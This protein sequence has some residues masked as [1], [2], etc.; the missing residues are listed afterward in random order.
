M[1]FPLFLSW[2]IL[3]KKG[4]VPFCSQL[5]VLKIPENLLDT[6]LQVALL[7][8]QSLTLT[9]LQQSTAVGKDHKFFAG[10]FP[11]KRMHTCQPQNFEKRETFL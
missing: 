4:S 11:T 1:F 6:L 7:Q 8:C 5:F 10:F 2:Q 3:A 9:G